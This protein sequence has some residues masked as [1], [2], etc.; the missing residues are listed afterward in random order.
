MTNVYFA[1]TNGSAPA[2]VRRLRRRRQFPIMELIPRHQPA[3]DGTPHEQTH[4]SELALILVS[5]ILINNFVLTQFLGH[6]PS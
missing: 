3:R 6:D 1:P 2:T 4:M 5:S